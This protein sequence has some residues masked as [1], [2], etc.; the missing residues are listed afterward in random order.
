MQP[1]ELFVIRN[2][3]NLV[4]PYEEDNAY[5]GTSAGLEFAVRTLGV[6]HIIVFGHA[7]CGGIMSLFQKSERHRL[8]RVLF[9]SGWNLHNQ[10]MMR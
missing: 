3:A 2:V 8:K 4:P 5:H 7:Q 10:P 6:K 1:G 9:P